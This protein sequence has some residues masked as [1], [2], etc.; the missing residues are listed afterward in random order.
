MRTYWDRIKIGKNVKIQEGT[1]LG[2]L[3]FIFNRE[4]GE[5]V[6]PEIK[7]GIDIGDNV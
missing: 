1:I 5:R 7:G 2:A 4:T 6:R 3:P